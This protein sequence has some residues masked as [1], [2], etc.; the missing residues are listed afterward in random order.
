MV[1]EGCASSPVTGA[2]FGCEW[3]VDLA[4]VDV[5]G[6]PGSW[7]PVAVRWM[8]VECAAASAAACVR[9]EVGGAADVCCA[10]CVVASVVVS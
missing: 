9:V 10:A 7:C 6:V 2:G 1:A 5:T 3:P 4:V 8:L